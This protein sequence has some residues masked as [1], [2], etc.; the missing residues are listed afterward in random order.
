MLG[1]RIFKDKI[2]DKKEK[3]TSSDFSDFFRK[4]SSAEK[5]RVFNDVARKASEAQRAYM[6]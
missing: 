5:K 6:Q 2:L 1:F 4:A 3:P